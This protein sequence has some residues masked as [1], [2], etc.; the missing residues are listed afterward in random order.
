LACACAGSEGGGGTDPANSDRGGS[1]S[2]ASAGRQKAGC[3]NLNTAAADELEALPGIG[4]VTARK[5][6]EHRDRFGPFR[7][8]EEVIIVDGMSA[9]KYR[10]IADRL[11]VD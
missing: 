11:C 9:R 2:A 5:I 4:A 7:R 10:A 3:V 1:V 6:I 8:T